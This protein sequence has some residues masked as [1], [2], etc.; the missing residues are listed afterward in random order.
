MVNDTRRDLLTVLD[1]SKLGLF[2]A[3]AM[4]VCFVVVALDGFDTQSVAFVAPALRHTWDVSPE[5]FGPLFG[6]GLLGTL[7]GSIAF[8]S[9]ADRFGRKPMLMLST[10]LFGLMTL[11]CATA[12]SIEQL[13]TYRFIAGLG[14][15]GAIPNVLALISEYSPK[16]VRSTAIVVTFAG[17]PIG[18]VL[19]GMGSARLIPAFGWESVFVIGGLLPIL[20]LPAIG[21]LVPESARFL[22][23]RPERRPKLERILE[24]V[25]PAL[26]ADERAAIR[27]PPARG[28]SVPVRSLFSEGRASW[29]LLLWGLTFTTL[30]L[31]Y[32]LVNWTPLLLVDAGLDHHQ[33]IM[34]VVVLNLGGVLGGFLI[35]RISD[36]SGPFRALAV[37]YLV[38]A[39]FV[40]TVGFMI[41]SPAGT[42]LALIFVVGFCVFGAQLNLSAVSAIYYPVYMRSTGIGWN[43]GIGRFGSVVGPTVGGALIAFGLDQGQMFLSA[44]VPAILAGSI[45]IAMAF[46]TPRVSESEADGGEQGH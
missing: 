8:G 43:M 12:S 24:R 35:G 2:Q 4:F 20:M 42:L 15:G 28:T 10:L 19:G 16:S 3:G 21:F 27:L 29:T 45:V 6:A 31:G 5:L 17:F 11:A 38:G 23:G 14:L 26:T 34:G 40:A 1:E 22:S 32:F 13:G 46:K 9:L 36:R 25:A 7:V 41:G 37:A 44:A 18:A 30:L 33:A 39:V